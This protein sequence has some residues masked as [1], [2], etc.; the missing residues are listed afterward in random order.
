M[1]NE[2]IPKQISLNLKVEIM[3]YQVGGSIVEAVEGTKGFHFVIDGE[4]I[5]PQ[6]D[7]E[8]CFVVIDGSRL[9]VKFL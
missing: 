6:F 9:S 4:I 7:D 8:S 3:L 2:D 5:V 1:Y